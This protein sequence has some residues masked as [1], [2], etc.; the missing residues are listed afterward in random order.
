[1]DKCIREIWLE[2]GRIGGYA[3]DTGEGTED[4]GEKNA[5]SNLRLRWLFVALEVCWLERD[6][7]MLGIDFAQ[8]CHFLGY[9]T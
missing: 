3:R 9:L 4:A 1:M 7:W 6:R 5:D 2:E 8:F